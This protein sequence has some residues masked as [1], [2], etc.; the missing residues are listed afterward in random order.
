MCSSIPTDDDVE[1]AGLPLDGEVLGGDW[2]CLSGAVEGVLAAGCWLGPGRCH[3]GPVAL[4]GWGCEE[5]PCLW[6]LFRG[7][8]SSIP[9]DGVKL[10]W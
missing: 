4:S 3:C 6:C 9:Y 2:L 5:C 7:G 10:H 1:L 8:K